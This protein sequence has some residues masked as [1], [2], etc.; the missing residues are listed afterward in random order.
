MEEGFGYYCKKKV[1]YKYRAFVDNPYT[2]ALLEKGDVFFSPPAL[3]NDLYDTRLLVSS[4]SRMKIEQMAKAIENRRKND[5][6]VFC[7]SEVPDSIPMWTYYGD[8]NAGI[9]IG[10]R[11]DKMNNGYYGLKLRNGEVVLT[12][13]SPFEPVPAYQVH[14]NRAIPPYMSLDTD[15]RNIKSGFEFLFNK[16]KQLEHE[17]EIRVV[18][19]KTFSK[20]EWPQNDFKGIVY[21][22]DKGVVESICLGPAFD[23]SN[24]NVIKEL[25]YRPDTACSGAKLY[26]MIP[27]RKYYRYNKK[28]IQHGLIGDFQEYVVREYSRIH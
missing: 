26:I 14:Y 19:S 21:H 6:A 2:K 24:I 5:M 27:D 22:L 16:P 13:E 23:Y 15:E 12:E 18:V 28:E 25:I 4:I 9:C 17:R 8:N 1:A 20:V 10:L 11:L 7:M 3:F